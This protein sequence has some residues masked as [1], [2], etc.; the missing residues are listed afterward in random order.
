MQEVRETYRNI[1]T[2]KG[3]YLGKISGQ[4]SDIKSLK[5]KL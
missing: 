3:F 5:K 4:R 1:V 2:D